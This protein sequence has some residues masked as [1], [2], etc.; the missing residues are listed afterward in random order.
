MA[1]ANERY[2]T[3]AVIMMVDDGARFAKL[4]AM[5]QAPACVSPSALAYFALSK[6][7]EVFGTRTMQRPNIFDLTIPV[8]ALAQRS[9]D[10][11]SDDIDGERT[12]AIKE[13]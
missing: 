9:A 12:C 11:L 1:L 8:R 7:R 6:K 3:D 4:L 10:R 13:A 2:G 5:M